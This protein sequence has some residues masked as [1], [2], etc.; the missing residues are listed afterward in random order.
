MEQ[1]KNMK[2]L[3]SVF[4]QLSDLKIYFHKMESFV[5]EML[6]FTKMSVY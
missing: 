2:L 3:L 4:E 6:N 5:M 1:A